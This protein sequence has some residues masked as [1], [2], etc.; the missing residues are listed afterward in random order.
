MTA[1]QIP[2]NHQ[3]VIFKRNKL[4]SSIARPDIAHQS[5][6]KPVAL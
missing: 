1:H 2:E 6:I 4:K 5:V 3:V